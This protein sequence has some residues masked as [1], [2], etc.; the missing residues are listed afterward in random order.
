MMGTRKRVQTTTTILFS[1]FDIAAIISVRV[2]N[3]AIWTGGVTQQAKDSLTPGSGI[4]ARGF[5]TVPGWSGAPMQTSLGGFRTRSL[6]TLGV[7]SEAI[8]AAKGHVRLT[9]E[10]KH[11]QGG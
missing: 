3:V 5:T 8:L 10:S 4:K 6:R 2:L 1:N 11:V 9:S 7:P